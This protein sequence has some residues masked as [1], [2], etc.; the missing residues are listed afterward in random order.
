MRK[1]LCIALAITVCLGFAVVGVSAAEGEGENLLAG[2]TYTY[3]SGVTFFSPYTDDAR[4]LL[5][6]GKYRGDGNATFN[7]NHTATEGTSVGMVGD[8]TGNVPTETYITFTLAK[9]VT[10]E[11]LFFR[12]IRRNGNRYFNVAGV[13]TSRDGSTYTEAEFT[14]SSAVIPEAP[15]MGGAEEQFFNLTLTFKKAVRHVAYIRVHINT[16]SPV[17][18]QRKYLAQVDEIEAYGSDSNA[19]PAHAELTMQTAKSSVAVGATVQ[20]KVLIKN[21]KTPNGVVALDLPLVYDT[22]KLLLTDAVGIYPSS[23][24]NTG[25][26]VKGTD[27]NKTWVRVVCDADDLATNSAYN[28]KTDNVLG[29]T[30]TFRALAAGAAGITIDNDIDNDVYIFAVNGGDFENYGVSGASTN[31]IVTSS[32]SGALLGDVN[33]DGTVDNIDAVAVLRHEANV[34]ELKGDKLSRA[35][36]NGD[37]D[38]NNMDASAILRYDA[39]MPAF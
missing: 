24:K 27:G 12:G 36:F 35:D 19:Y 38:V 2:A 37:G 26:T 14:E 28:V 7:S 9:E 6:D 22:Q 8:G 32:S 3:S 17:D 18:N 23:W 5:T 1:L 33:G 31:V 11:S 10:L 4:T 21:I 34:E 13:E 29:V 39:G 30:L 20:V 25:F 16:L 15:L